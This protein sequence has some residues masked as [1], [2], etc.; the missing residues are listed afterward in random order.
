MDLKEEGLIAGPLERHWYYASKFAAL[1]RIIADSS[2][3]YGRPYSVLDVGAGSGFFS[4]QLLRA[5]LCGHA[6]CVDPGYESERDE[7]ESG[8]SLAFR[9][10]VTTSDSNLVL[11]MD[12]LEHVPDDVALVDLYRSKVAPRT[13]FVVTVPAFQFLWSGHDVFLEHYRRYTL[14]GIEAVLR[15]AGLVV[16]RGCYVFG[17]LFPAVTV[18]RFGQRLLPARP[19]RSAMGEP[20]L[21]ISALL[22]TIMAIERPVMLH[23]R[24]AGVTAVVRARV[25]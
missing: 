8:R 10:E 9:R 1:K 5:G 15:R 23:N 3:S 12:V 16:E 18:M 14:R 13:A 6:V 7:V 22:K 21:P 4:R 2:T 19:A 24:L 25:P 11:M 20:A 17:F